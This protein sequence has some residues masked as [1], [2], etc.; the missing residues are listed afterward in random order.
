MQHE[1]SIWR[2]VVSSYARVCARSI[3]L[4]ITLISLL[5]FVPA[6]GASTIEG[7]IGELKSNDLKTQYDGLEKIKAFRNPIATQALVKSAMQNS[8][9]NFRLAVLDQI[10]ALQ[11]QTVVPALSPLFSDKSIAIRQRTARVIGTLNGPRAEGVLMPAFANETD[12]SVKA[13]LIQSL[14]LCG[15]KQSDTL[16]NA[17]E[18]D[19]DPS[20]RANAIYAHK[21]ITDKKAN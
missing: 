20:I 3:F 21:R 12:P 10:G 9:I 2:E 13:A 7:A 15:S 8:D 6:F 19:A 17:A 14:G 5:F 11:D 18:K 16:L 1:H 4:Q